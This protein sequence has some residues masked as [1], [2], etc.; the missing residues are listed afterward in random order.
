MIR[1]CIVLVFATL[2]LTAATATAGSLSD[3]LAAGFTP[4]VPVSALGMMGSWFDPSRLHMSSTFSVGSSSGTGWGAG[5]N[6]LQTTSFSYAF[7][8]PVWMSV[9]VGNAFGPGAANGS[10]FF[11]QGLDLAYQPTAN[12]VFR[13]QFQ[14]V[15]SPLQYG[16]SMYAPG[17][18]PWGY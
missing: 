15:R 11:L 18:G 16:N 14:N 5:T 3:P 8:A 13:I 6:A 4:R 17:R 7:K 2:A 9:S 1:R 12:S 10:S